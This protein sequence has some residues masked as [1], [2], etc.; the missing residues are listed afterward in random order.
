[1]RLPL[2]NFEQKQ[3]CS[4]FLLVSGRAAFA[5][6]PRFGPMKTP[7]ILGNSENCFAR[8]T[9]LIERTFFDEP[10]FFTDLKLQYFPSENQAG[11]QKFKDEF[12][13]WLAFGVVRSIIECRLDTRPSQVQSKTT[14]DPKL[15]A[16]FRADLTPLEKS[17]ATA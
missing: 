16:E 5:C 6:V 9:C 15:D 14:R 1:M 2:V 8:V 10:E 11:N 17:Q 7:D 12:K 13:T 4:G 3:M